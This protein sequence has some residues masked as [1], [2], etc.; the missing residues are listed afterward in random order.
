[1]DVFNEQKQ[2]DEILKKVNFNNTLINLATNDP[3][4]I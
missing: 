4:L 3:T 2:I 1:M